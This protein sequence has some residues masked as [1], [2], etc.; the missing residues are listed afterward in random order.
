[1]DNTNNT[2]G[3][4]YA[5]QPQPQLPQ[6]ESQM[7]SPVPDGVNPPVAPESNGA[8]RKSKMP[9][10][11]AVVVA[12]I[13]II[14]AIIAIIMI[15]NSAGGDGQKTAK[16]NPAE[17]VIG[18]DSKD[19]SIIDIERNT[20]LMRLVAAVESYQTDNG[21]TLPFGENVRLGEDFIQRYIDT[22]CVSAVDN[23]DEVRYSSC[24]EEFSDFS[25]KGPFS[26]V[27]NGSAEQLKYDGDLADVS[28]EI[29]EEKTFYA[30]SF[31]YCGGGGKVLKG[32]DKY[33]VAIFGKLTTGEVIC[34]DNH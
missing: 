16:A 33:S 14:G 4:V 32:D 1:M 34:Q 7:T 24:S 21:G 15:G 6:M 30:Y 9:I 31:A 12:V 22:T 25:D 18:P 19:Y 28:G 26:V 2:G 3:Q 11:I 20:T 13:A 8:Q 29:K 5:Q 10:V 23:G 27:Y 17:T